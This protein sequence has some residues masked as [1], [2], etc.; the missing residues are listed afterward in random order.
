VIAGLVLA[1]GEGARFGGPKQLAEL[2]G[3]PL[4]EHALAAISAV[5]G[6]ERVVVVLGARADEIRAQVD[7][8]GSEPVVCMNWDEGQ[9]AS[10]RAGLAGLGE[11]D[12]VVVTLGDQPRITPEV[13]ALALGNFDGRRPVRTVYDGKPGHPVVLPGWMI[14]R[15]MELEGDVGARVL[16]DEAGVLEVEAGHLASAADV[17]TPADLEVLRR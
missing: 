11:A 10:L 12:A 3:R 4:L 1:A 13:I 8:M 9:A 14:P 5:P 7:L 6:I 15:V 2:D 16:L 17:D